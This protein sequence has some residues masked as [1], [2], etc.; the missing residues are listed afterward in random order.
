MKAIIKNDSKQE[1]IAVVYCGE[2]RKIMTTECFMCNFNEE[3]YCTGGP[4]SDQYCSFGE[5][6]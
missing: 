1:L 2:C 5:R 3:G 6:K 4:D